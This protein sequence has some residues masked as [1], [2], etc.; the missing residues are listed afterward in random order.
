MCDLR[1]FDKSNNKMTQ[2]IWNNKVIRC[3]KKYKRLCRILERC[4]SRRI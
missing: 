4:Q 1:L 2:A 3:I